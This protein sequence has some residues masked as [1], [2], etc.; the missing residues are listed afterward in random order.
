MARI[1]HH[2]FEVRSV[3]EALCARLVVERATDETLRALAEML[4]Q[5]E[6]AARHADA[7]TWLQLDRGFHEAVYRASDNLFLAKVL[8]E[9]YALDMRIWYQLLDRM[10]DLPRVVESHRAIVHAFLARD[11]RAAE[12][13]LMQH[14][15]ETQAMILPPGAANSA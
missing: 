6:D 9:L 5:F 13:A 8:R 10:T 7:Q 12:R 11:G 15:R 14:I 2:S 1:F 4:P 3:L